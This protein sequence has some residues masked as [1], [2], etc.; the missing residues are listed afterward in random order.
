VA[1][2][3]GLRAAEVVSLKVLG[4]LSTALSI[5]GLMAWP[6]EPVQGLERL[7]GDNGRSQHDV[8]RDERLGAASSKLPKRRCALLL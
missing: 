2:G 5:N 1:Y 8:T 7:K 3:A 6:I 4:I